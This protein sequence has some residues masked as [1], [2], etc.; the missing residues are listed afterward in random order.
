M[1]RH[2]DKERKL[3]A[4]Q[5]RRQQGGTPS[6]RGRDQTLTT[7]PS[8]LLTLPH[9]LIAMRVSW[10]P[11][12]VPRAAHARSTSE[13]LSFTGEMREFYHGRRS[14]GILLTT[15][16]FCFWSCGSHSSTSFSC[17]SKA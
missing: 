15:A 16:Y 4:R 11:G 9:T 13:P 12:W 5:Q 14:K 17:Q 1:S 2:V 6:D 7:V 10:A 8:N 3:A